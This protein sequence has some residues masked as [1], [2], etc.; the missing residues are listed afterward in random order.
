LLINTQI[1]SHLAPGSVSWLSYADR[2]ME[3]PTA[4]LGVALG[5]VLMPQ[6]AAAKA[7]GDTDRYAAMLDW[8]LRLVLLLALPCAAALLVFAEPL[9][10][11]LYHYGAFTDRD[12]QQTTLSLTG[13]GIG[14][15]G[16]VAI[17]V[18]APGYYASQDIRTPVKIAVVVLVITQ[19]FNL[20]FVP[21]LQHAGLALSIGL[22]ALVNALW[23][24]IGLLRRGSY[25]PQP[26]WWRFGLQVVLATSLVTALL[27]VAAHQLQ[28][29]SLRQTPW[30][31]IGWML[32]VLLA[33][34]LLYFGT[35]W[36]TGLRLK[37]FLKR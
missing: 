5:A 31:R 8:G 36:A 2:L 30:L 1:A 22:G 10:S 17:K 18:L 27:W 26:G 4:L 25:K 35:L 20:M 16:L 23:L 24:L 11:V 9:V 13:Y 3:F 34:A 6:L 21:W 14:L 33:S 12:V 7:T 19:L 32:S 28:W 29:V 15:L 37:A